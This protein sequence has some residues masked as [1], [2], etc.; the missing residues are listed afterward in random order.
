MP[1]RRP[2]KPDIAAQIL[3]LEHIMAQGLDKLITATAYLTTAV[4]A[5][6]AKLNEPNTEDAAVETLAGT[7]QAG[8]DQLNAAVNPPAPVV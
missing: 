1:P 8:A 4:N 7:V 5:V 3:Q 2:P 6:L